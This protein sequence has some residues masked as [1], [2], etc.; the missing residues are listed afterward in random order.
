MDSN[1]TK[2]LIGV[3]VLLGAAMA[4]TQ[5]APVQSSSPRCIVDVESEYYYTGIPR[6]SELIAPNSSYTEERAEE[7][8]RKLRSE[9]DPGLF[10]FFRKPGALA[11]V[12]SG[13]VQT[14]YLEELDDFCING[15]GYKRLDDIVRELIGLGFLQPVSRDIPGEGVRLEVVNSAYTTVAFQSPATH[16]FSVTIFDVPRYHKSAEQRRQLSEQSWD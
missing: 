13:E 5:R 16:G 6:F 10:R 4:C 3:T 2:K 11:V 12:T 8:L 15:R 1:K 9:Q 7:V 14:L